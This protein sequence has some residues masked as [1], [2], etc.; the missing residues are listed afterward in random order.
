MKKRILVALLILPT[1]LIGCDSL[2]DKGDVEKT[3]DGP[4]QIGLFPLEDNNDLS[5]GDTGTSIEVQLIAK[6][7]KSSDLSIGFSADP[8]STA[9][10]GV[11]YTFDTPSP[12]TLAAGTSTV[13]IEISFIDGSVPANSEVLLILNLNETQG[14][15]L[16]ENLKSSNVFIAN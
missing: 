9:Q 11:H 2:F 6:S 15:E 7:Q 10:E 14:V 3:Y 12:V 13:D 5:N 16:A 1:L 4:D 8:S